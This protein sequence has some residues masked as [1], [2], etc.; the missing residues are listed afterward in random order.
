MA[1]STTTVVTTTTTEEQGAP[2]SAQLDQ[3]ASE[4]L[5][6]GYDRNPS[7]VRMVQLSLAG[8][9]SDALDAGRAQGVFDF[10]SDLMLWKCRGGTLGGY[11][12][13]RIGL[14]VL[15]AAVGYG[16]VAPMAR[17][18]QET[19]RAGVRASH[20]RPCIGSMDA[21]RRPSG[22]VCFRETRTSPIRCSYARKASGQGGGRS[23]VEHYSEEVPTADDLDAFLDAHYPPVSGLVVGLVSMLVGLVLSAVA[24]FVWR[25]YAKSQV[26]RPEAL[27]TE[28]FARTM[29]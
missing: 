19:L 2:L 20:A 23:R 25:W 10:G 16:L 27:G 12:L 24:N 8:A 14:A 13:W 26:M 1:P 5:Y 29:F 6:E 15:L 11:L 21:C 4:Q 9:G 3:F 18:Q 28:A 17:R 7:C 22:A